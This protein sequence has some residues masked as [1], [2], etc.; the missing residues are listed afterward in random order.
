MIVQ[1][2]PLC[3]MWMWMNWHVMCLISLSLYDVDESMCDVFWS[4]LD[5][6][7]IIVIKLYNQIMIQT[8]SIMLWI[9]IIKSFDYHNPIT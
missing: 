8:R 7:M 6:L 4:Y 3:V 9:I 2:L 5:T 1:S